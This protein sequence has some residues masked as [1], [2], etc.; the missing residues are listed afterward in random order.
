MR[1]L[2]LSL[3]RRMMHNVM[4]CGEEAV[5]VGEPLFYKRSS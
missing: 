3:K 5:V 1:S 4:A 2:K